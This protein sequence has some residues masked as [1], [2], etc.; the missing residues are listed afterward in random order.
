[1]VRETLPTSPFAYVVYPLVS[2]GFLH[3]V[4]VGQGH[5]VYCI[6]Y[7][8]ITLTPNP[9]PLNLLYKRPCVCSLFL[10]CVLLRG[11]ATDRVPPSASHRHPARLAALVLLPPSRLRVTE[12]LDVLIWQVLPGP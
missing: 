2:K 12:L 10:G 8:Y 4:H 5:R 9:K 7:G 6:P 1:M 3:V 11:V